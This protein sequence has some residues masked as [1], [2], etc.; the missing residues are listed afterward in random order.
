MDYLLFHCAK[1]SP[2][3]EALIQ[4]IGTWS[5]SKQDLIIKYQ[6]EFSA[7]VESTDFDVLQ[8]AK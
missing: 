4:Q 6:M 1:N 7:F 8:S 3:T 5:A 2:Q